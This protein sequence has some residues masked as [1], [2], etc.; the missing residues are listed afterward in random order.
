M[1]LYV[2]QLLLCAAAVMAHFSEQLLG[3]TTH[4]LCLFVVSF[5]VAELLGCSG[6]EEILKT[7][8]SA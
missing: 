8:L 3:Y 4:Q 1:S 7:L 6:A 5:L 2:C